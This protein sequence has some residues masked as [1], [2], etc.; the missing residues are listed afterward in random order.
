MI[1]TISIAFALLATPASAENIV[2]FAA[3]S[4][5][6]ALDDIV[7]EWNAS[8]DDVVIVS[9]AGSGALAQQIRQ[10]APADVFISANMQW[11]NATSDYSIAQIDLLS[12]E[13]VIVAGGNQDPIEITDLPILLGNEKLAMA[14]VNAVP[15]GQYGKAA[16]EHFGLWDD[17]APNVA[18]TDNVR[19]AL[20][21]VALGEAPFGV[22]YATDAAAEPDVS[23][24]A[25][26]PENSHPPITYPAA[27]LTEN[28]RAFFD[29]LTGSSAARIFTENGFK[30]LN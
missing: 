8:H 10:G 30:V 26:F 17:I 2:A 13:L 18:Q 27:L 28:G 12:N 1:R 19:A 23:V 24:V 6:T 16:F 7:A 22:V 5:K 14:L 3:A 15:A 21:L 4:L 20:A 9:Y 29:T 11:M 25:K